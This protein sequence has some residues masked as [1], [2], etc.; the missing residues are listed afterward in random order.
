MFKVGQKIKWL[1]LLLGKVQ[2]AT[3]EIVEVYPSG[4]YANV[5][6]E[7]LTG[8]KITDKLN[9]GDSSITFL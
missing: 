1:T 6:G 4:E 7:T 5:K 9:V 3:G 8:V 2:F